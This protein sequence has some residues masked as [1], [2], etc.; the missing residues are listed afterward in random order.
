MARFSPPAHLLGP[1]RSV[2]GSKREGYNCPREEPFTASERLQGAS[3]TG[4]IPEGTELTG[5]AKPRARWT[6]IGPVKGALIA[7]GG[8]QSRR[9]E[10][11]RTLQNRSCSRRGALRKESWSPRTAAVQRSSRLQLPKEMYR[12]GKK[13]ADIRR[14][15]IRVT[16]PGSSTGCGRE[17]IAVTI[18]G[19]PR[20]I[21]TFQPH[22]MHGQATQRRVLP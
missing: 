3:Q 13:G 21:N 9:Q 16:N 4:A 2:I 12:D 19:E 15:C 18:G 1:P 6:V 22:L 20:Q 11:P 17:R 7:P 14:G 10:D 5:K 8:N